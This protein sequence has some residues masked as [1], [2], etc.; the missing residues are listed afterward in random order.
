MFVDVKEMMDTFSKTLILRKMPTSFLQG[1]LLELVSFQPGSDGSTVT[2]PAPRAQQ[3]GP[4][5]PPPQQLY[6]PRPPSHHVFPP[7]HPAHSHPTPPASNA[8]IPSSSTASGSQQLP[9]PPW[10]RW[11]T[12]ATPSMPPATQKRLPKGPE[13]IHGAIPPPPGLPNRKRKYHDE[14]SPTDSLD[15]DDMY[16]SSFPLKRHAG[17][18]LTPTPTSPPR[19]AQTL[20]PSLAM[21]VSPTN[22]EVH[23][24]PRTATQLPPLR[25]GPNSSPRLP[26]VKTLMGSENP[27]RPL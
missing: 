19:P 13:S 17:P 15:K 8:Q 23:T 24:S 11:G 21:I 27:S 18:D 22:Q 26:P 12:V 5:M 20:S 4:S 25:N 1:I 7:H 9:T 16:G 3:A 6:P 14:H 10:A 2:G